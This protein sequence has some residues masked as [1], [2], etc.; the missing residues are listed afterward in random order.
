MS[1]RVI[2]DGVEIGVSP[3]IVHI[4]LGDNGV[5]QECPPQEAQGFCV[6]LPREDAQVTLDAGVDPSFLADS[7]DTPYDAGDLLYDTVFSLPGKNLARAVGEATW[8]EFE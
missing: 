6:K 7:G 5:Y 1:Y 3:T 2:R 8:Q 4:Y